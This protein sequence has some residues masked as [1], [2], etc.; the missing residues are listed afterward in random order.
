PA[1]AGVGTRGIALAI[2]ALLAQL[3][4]LVIAGT[5]AL[6]DSIVSGPGSG[7]LI[8]ALAGAGWAVVVCG[9]FLTFWTGAGQTPGMRLM[10]LRLLASS[11]NPP[12]LFR[13]AV[14]L[15][16]LA[17]AIAIVFLGFVPVLVDDRRRALQDFLAGTTVYYDEL[18]P[19]PAAEPVDDAVALTT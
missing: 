12:G 13:A 15:V 4:F 8:G 18:A 19:T 2:D 14:R 17:V 16:G 6:V 5:F 3:I 9:Y 10:R 11:G 7:W 1:Q